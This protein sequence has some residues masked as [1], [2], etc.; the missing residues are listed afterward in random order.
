MKQLSLILMIVALMPD[1]TMG[2]RLHYPT[3]DVP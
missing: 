2:Q 3:P 1:V